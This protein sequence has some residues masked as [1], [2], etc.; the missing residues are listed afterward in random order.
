ML[1][2]AC[3]WEFSFRMLQYYTGNVYDNSFF[4]LLLLD[5][6]LWVQGE[7]KKSSLFQSPS[8]HSMEAI[9][10]HSTIMAD[11]LVELG[12]LSSTFLHATLPEENDFSEKK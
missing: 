10:L 7:R 12:I 2:M 1:K 4:S 9:S 6:D 11:Q 8:A 5:E 3:P